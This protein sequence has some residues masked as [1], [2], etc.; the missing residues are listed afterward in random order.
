MG[1]DLRNRSK[2]LLKE[3][4]AEMSVLQV[5]I[6]LNSVC[7]DPVYVTGGG[8]GWGGG[9][10]HV[11]DIHYIITLVTHTGFYVII[12]LPLNHPDCLP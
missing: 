1:D 10:G 12:F 8:G 11:D 6:T 5:H 9:W 2:V 3:T 4:S 7:P